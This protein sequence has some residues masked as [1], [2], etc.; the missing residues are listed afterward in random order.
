MKKYYEEI[1]VARGIAVLLVVLGHSFPDGTIGIFN[2][3]R[4]YKHI[5]NYIYS[6]HMPLFF[7]LSGF[8]SYKLLQVEGVKEKWNAVIHK[9]KRLLVPYIVISI[10]SLILKYMF[11]GSA[12]NSFNFSETIPNLL[13]GT[14]PNTGLWFLYVLFL[15]STFII[16]FN[17]VKIE[18]IIGA[19]MLFRITY[20]VIPVPDICQLD[21]I[22]SC[23]SFYFIGF[24][25]YK[26]YDIVQKVLKN[27]YALI[28]NIALFIALNYM[29][30]EGVIANAVPSLIFSNVVATIVTLCGCMAVLSISYLLVTTGKLSSLKS[31]F[32]LC[33]NYGYDIYI[34]SYFIQTPV[35]VIMYS[36]L[37]LNYEI[38]LICMIVSGVLLSIVIGYF[39]RKISIL[40]KLV[41]GNF[42]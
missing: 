2:D 22:Q 26:H 9:A 12:Y 20:E 14:N 4:I 13:S 27:K 16:I 7:M 35:R 1:N 28:I 11:S 34:I 10:P 15:E 38:I 33:G 37:H 19:F 39:V 40:N 32:N 6:F 41:L 21:L 31:I 25:L 3:N 17:K 36:K 30:L 8:V 42:K 5:F 29:M 24:W 23:G 18:Y